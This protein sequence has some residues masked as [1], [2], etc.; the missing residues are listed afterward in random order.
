ML[1][2]LYSDCN[3]AQMHHFWHMA[4]SLLSVFKLRSDQW[5]EEL[6]QYLVS[7]T[8]QLSSPPPPPVTQ[9]CSIV[10]NRQL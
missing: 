8:K 10:Y 2:A 4:S 1:F 5:Q 9:A 3:P 6:E 7:S